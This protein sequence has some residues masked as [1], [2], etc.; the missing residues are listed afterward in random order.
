MASPQKALLKAL[1]LLKALQAPLR[2]LTS[3]KPVP[4]PSPPPLSSPR[5][6]RAMYA[7]P[8]PA[9]ATNFC[10]AWQE[11]AA[12]A[13]AATLPRVMPPLQPVRALMS[14]SSLT[15]SSHCGVA[16]EGEVYSASCALDSSAAAP[17]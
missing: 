15:S 5:A 7:P 14:S 13:M 3:R 2:P 8:P 1:Y 6:P 17:A 10:E 9:P 11:A 12:M 4:P 16:L